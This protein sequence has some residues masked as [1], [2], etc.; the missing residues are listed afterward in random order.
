MSLLEVVLREVY[1][2]QNGYAST[3]FRHYER[4]FRDL[5][6]NQFR[7]NASRSA[8]TTGPRKDSISPMSPR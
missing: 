8:S 4:L 5:G 1:P 7:L 6:F 3:L 2:R